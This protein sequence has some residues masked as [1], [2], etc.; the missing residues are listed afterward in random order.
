MKQWRIRRRFSILNHLRYNHYPP[1]P[2][3]MVG[4][5]ERAIDNANRGEWNKRVLLPRG[6][7]YRGIRLAPTHAIID[8]HHL[9]FYVEGDEE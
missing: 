7:T 4:P 1:V 9:E 6:V 8:Q 5:C 2:A 3:S